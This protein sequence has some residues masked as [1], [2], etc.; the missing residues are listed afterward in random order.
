MRAIPIYTEE[1]ADDFVDPR[2]I[3]PEKISVNWN[4]DLQLLTAPLVFDRSVN[5]LELSSHQ[6]LLDAELIDKIDW[7]MPYPTVG[8]IH[9]AMLGSVT[10]ISTFSGALMTFTDS[11]KND[12]QYL[13]A[14]TRIDLS[15]DKFLASHS[16]CKDKF[17]LTIHLD[18]TIN[19]VTGLV[20][21][22]AACFF[23]FAN[24][25]PKTI[26]QGLYAGI[27]PLGYELIAVRSKK[28]G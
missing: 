19:L 21:I 7:L 15:V 18:G 24:T 28:R 27:R 10:S 20:N 11:D 14:K 26:Q 6:A 22:K 2:S 8:R 9:L 12:V 25:T 16:P 4:G 17:R 1:N 13:E 23:N 5:V 3:E